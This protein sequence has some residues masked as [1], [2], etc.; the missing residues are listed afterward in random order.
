MTAD[1]GEGKLARPVDGEDPQHAAA[2]P[3][4]AAPQRAPVPSQTSRGATAGPAWRQALGRT[5]GQWA[6]AVVPAIGLIE[7]GAHL[8]QA[9]GATSDADWKAARD[10][11]ASQVHPEDLVTFA[12]RWVDPIGRMQFGPALATL[13]R[14]ARPDESRFPRAFEVSIRGAHDPSLAG[15]SRTE[16]HRFGDV[17]VATLQNPSP[18]HVLDDLVSLVNAERMQVSR[19]EAGHESGHESGYESEC[20]FA[21]AA[22]QSGG[23]GAGPALPADRFVCP[24]GGFVAASVAADLSYYAH[25]CIYAPPPGGKS[26]LRLRFLGVRLGQTLH[27]HHGLYVEAERG[28]TGAPITITFRS[29]ETV[30]G[31]VVHHDGDGWKPFEFDTSALAAQARQASDGKADI[32]ADIESPSGER[33]MYC[34]EADTR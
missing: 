8:V 14:E 7:L 30:I 16:E 25:R 23:L 29:G 26:G 6:F 24:S 9:H 1:E 34:F 12:P 2:H 22:P 15:W 21:H 28:R 19:A 18:A 4:P 17:T 20:A 10:Y 11:V 3:V 32:V 13:E 33:R 31:S 5:L 27:G